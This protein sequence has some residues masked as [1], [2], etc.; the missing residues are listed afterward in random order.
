MKIVQKGNKQLRIKD[1]HLEAKLKA[2]YVEIDE[3]TGKPV[4]VKN[5]EPDV[6]VLEA[7]IKALK[8]ENAELKEQIKTLSEKKTE[9]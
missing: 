1:E 9:Q 7:E 5:K 3:K 4:K 8:A 2:G 6:K